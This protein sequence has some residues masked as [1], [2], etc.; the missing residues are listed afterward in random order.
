MRRAK[1]LTWA[2]TP[3]RRRYLDLPAGSFPVMAADLAALHRIFTRVGATVPPS[4]FRP[5]KF[6]QAQ[7]STLVLLT[8]WQ[9]FEQIGKDAR[10]K[11]PEIAAPMEV[12]PSVKMLGKLGYRDVIALVSS[13]VE[14]RAALGLR[15]VPDFSTLCHHRRHALNSFLLAHLKPFRDGR[16]D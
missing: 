9:M 12:P 16:P 4:K 5:K 2:C 11:F 1:N 8:K 15:T 14:I 13:S 6:T 7:L 3:K 10:T